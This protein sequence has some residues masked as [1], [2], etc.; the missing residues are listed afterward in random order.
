VGEPDVKKERETK[1]EGIS[2]I[3][4]SSHLRRLFRLAAR[5]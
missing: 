1:G 5:W 3:V 4:G 2:F